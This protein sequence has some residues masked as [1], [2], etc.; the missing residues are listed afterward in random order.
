MKSLKNY[1]LVCLSFLVLMSIF[2][3]AAVIE[4]QRTVT[5][6]Q[7]RL[8]EELTVVKNNIER[9]IVSR[10]VNAKGLAAMLE[11]H[12]TFTDEEFGIFAK[13]IYESTGYVVKDVVLITDTTITHVYPNYYGKGIIG[14]DLA[15]VPEQRDVLLYA[16]VTGKSVFFGPVDLVEGGKGIIVRVPVVID[17]G[18]FGQIAI[19]FDYHNFLKISGI[20]DLIK[21]NYIALMGSDPKSGESTFIWYNNRD[22]ASDY[23]AAS[24]NIDDIHWSITARPSESWN[25]FSPLFY[26]ILISGV[27]FCSITSAVYYRQLQLKG[28]LI[29]A[30]KELKNSVGSLENSKVKLEYHFNEIKD[31]EAYIQYLADHDSLTKLY[32]RRVFTETISRELVAGNHGV[33]ILIDLD[34]FKNINDIHGHIYGDKVLNN[35]A[36]I[37]QQVIDKR[38][39]VYR[40]GG[41]EFLILFLGEMPLDE[42]EKYLE[43]IKFGFEEQLV[44]NVN[45]HI[46][47]SAGV[48]R[49][50]LDGN[51]VE[52]LLIKSDVAMYSAKYAGKNRSAFFTEQLL[53]KFDS[54]IAI[55]NTLRHGLTNNGFCMYYQPIIDIRNGSVCSVEALLR[56][57]DFQYSPMEFIPVAEEAGIIIPLGLWVIEEVV[58]QIKV[59]MELGLDVKPVAINLSPKQLEDT[60]FVN[61]FFG[62]LHKHSVPAKFVEVEITESVLLENQE[63]N[64]SV[65]NTLHNAGIRISLDD[66]GTGYSSLNY[67]TYLPVD[68]V[69]LDKSLKDKFINLDNP[70]VLI[71]IIGMSHGLDLEV[72]AEGVENQEE[73]ETL[74]ASGCD[75]LQG[76]LFSRPIPAERIKDLFGQVFKRT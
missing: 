66:F 73:W 44:G 51:E 46:T 24:I 55:E 42:I 50:P 52:S 58:C 25:G 2:M 17:G 7:S 60:N 45:N 75:Y 18:Y 16:K 71:G 22:I 26:T 56:L 54:R 12:E 40:F 69:K 62:I 23:V 39:L 30:N 49:Y 61:I 76:Y 1:V 35:C 10:I 74:M 8:E 33:I 4:Y 19:V 59:W 3:V 20:K 29:T 15:E 38:G 34:N 65:L 31:K 57:K 28:Q 13:G 14:I 63:E 53:N 21:D 70:Q 9:M 36:V 27:V 32:N 6:E 64:I 48:V 11:I 68:K 43:Q 72:V 5:D 67:L 37:L 41:D 47:M